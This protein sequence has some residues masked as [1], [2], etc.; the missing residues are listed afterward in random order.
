MIRKF[1]VVAIPIRIVVNRFGDH[2]P[3][4]MMYVLKE[5]ESLSKKTSRK[6][7]IILQLI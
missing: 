4:G 3:E 1:H 2:D 5:N 6:K 7:S